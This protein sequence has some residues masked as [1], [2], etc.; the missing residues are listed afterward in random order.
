MN[1]DAHELL[2][3]LICLLPATLALFFGLLFGLL[4]PEARATQNAAGQCTVL[5]PGG[6]VVGLKNNGYAAVF[7]VNFQQ[8]VAEQ[9][10]KMAGRKSFGSDYAAALSFVESHPVNSTHVCYLTA[11][12]D[13]SFNQPSI[14]P[15]AITLFVLFG[16]LP[17]FVV[18]VVGIVKTVAARRNHNLVTPGYF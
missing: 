5:P 2:W 16:V 3:V 11:D 1:K 17:L 18:L 6:Q 15:M 12:K 8:N 14:S 9:W 13:A 10:V 4:L 7:L